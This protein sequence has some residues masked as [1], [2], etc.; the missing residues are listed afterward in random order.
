M[1]PSTSKSCSGWIIFYAGCPVSWASKLQSQVALFTTEAEYIAMSQSLR[2]VIPIMGLLQEIRKQNC[3]VLCTQP[4]VYWKVF[5]DNSGALELT[6][7]PKLCPRTKHINVCY[8]HFSGKCAQ[9]THQ[10]LPCG[11]QGPDC[12][13]THQTLGTK[14]LSTLS[15]LHVRQVTFTSNQSEGVLRTVLKCWVWYFGTYVRVSCTV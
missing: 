13:R 10:D 12:W 1:D 2:D 11:H 4:Y 5:E 15:L 6:R 8:H 14:W 7:L 3:N 9:G